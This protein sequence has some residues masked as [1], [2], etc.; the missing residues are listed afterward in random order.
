MVIVPLIYGSLRWAIENLAWLKDQDDCG[1]MSIMN[2]RGRCSGTSLDWRE[3]NFMDAVSVDGGKM[4]VF[5][6][7]EL[8]QQAI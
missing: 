5:V 4:K 2:H 6:I 8:V 3:G 7:M 1:K